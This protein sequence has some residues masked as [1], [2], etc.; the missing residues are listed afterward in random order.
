VRLGSGRRVVFGRDADVTAA[1]PEA[2]AASCAI[3]GYFVPVR[4][5]EFRY[6]DGGVHSPTNADVLAGQGLDL[7]IVS[8]AM[9]AAREAACSYRDPSAPLLAPHSPGSCRC[10]A[11]GEPG[12]SCSRLPHRSSRNGAPEEALDPRR[13]AEVARA[14][15]IAAW[16]RAQQ[17]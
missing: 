15:R 16:R 10:C 14:A 4:I 5:G 6:V 12:S 11:H 7:V 9:S 1:V 13:R 8:S 17:I 2:V 3:P